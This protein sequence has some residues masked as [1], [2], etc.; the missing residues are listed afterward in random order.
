MSN[1]I[2]LTALG[3]A[4]FA[5]R[6]SIPTDFTGASVAGAGDVNGD[7]FDDLLIGSPYAY[8]GA[9]RP[10]GAHLIFGKA[11]GFATVNL[12]SLAAADGFALVGDA[13]N[14][15]A[16]R[17]VASA[18]DVNGDG[19]DD[20]I[21]AA[22]YGDDGGSNAGEAYVVFGKASGLAAVD[23]GALAEGDGAVLR[24]VAGDVA[25]R[26]VAGAGDFNGDGIGD[27]IVGATGKDASG[28]DSGGAY[29]VFGKQTLGGAIDMGALGDA[30]GFWIQG[31]GAF[32]FMGRSVASAG[33]I[34][35]DGFDDLLV[36]APQGDSG[37]TDAG[38]AYVIFGRGPNPGTINLAALTPSL[39]FIVKGGAGY[40]GAGISVASAG[41]VN[42]DGFADMLVAASGADPAGTTYVVFGK[43][44]GFGTVDLGAL[45]PK[46][47]FAIRGEAA[48]LNTAISV[49]SA[50]DFN[51]DGFDDL[52]IGAPGD[53]YFQADSGK[54]YI[55]YGKAE[56]F[57]PID[58]GS[59]DA[60]EGMVITGG[61]YSRV[62]YSVSSAG[63]VNGD[64][65][66]DVIVGDPESH[67][68]Q[69]GSG[70]AYVIFGSAPTESVTRIGTRIAQSIRGGLGD[71]LLDGRDG[72][73]LLFGAGGDDLLI[74][75]GG[76]DAL[77]GDAGDDDLSGGS[78]HD[79]LNGGFDNDRLTGGSG[80][81][82]LDG[83]AGA[84][85][86]I[87]GSGNDRY[88]V[89]RLGDR[90]V[91]E[92]GSGAD[93]LFARANYT[94]RE[95]VDIETIGT[96][97]NTGTA[98][99]SLTG[100]EIAN[101]ITGNAGVNALAGGGGA[102]QLFGLAGNDR[103]S[104]GAGNDM[105]TGG[106]GLD[107]FV[108][109]TALSASANV[110]RL[111]DFTAVDDMIALDRSIFGGIPSGVL[112][113]AAFREGTAAQD[114]S[115]RIIYDAATGNIFYDADGLNGAAQTLF[116]R[117]EAGTPLTRVDFLGFDAAA[118]ASAQLPQSAFATAPEHGQ[119][120]G[121]AARSIH[122]DIASYSG[123]D[124]MDV[125]IA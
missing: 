31:S 48:M 8:S 110:D 96:I 52:I 69:T 18:G 94:L 73:D 2:D 98:A 74:G 19:L 77:S 43:A 117:V 89:D 21:V 66:D 34:N 28:T 42:G 15:R 13:N 58:L 60:H 1:L 61:L 121:I 7:G 124:W 27:L 38:Q 125:Q 116:A 100:N 119:G 4:G 86:L 51:G 102:D 103:L 46:A 55:V 81:D 50:G 82:Q 63:D 80:N 95:G 107:R 83:G 57:G 6:G 35:R 33:D 12:S 68:S 71:D 78:G 59:L 54:A 23:L 65:F 14:D 99:I 47:G 20:F 101:A 44:T 10:G 3:S 97:A 104:G 67:I 29:V 25:G 114:D 16:G 84:D 45:A 76:D 26:S 88:I 93:R 85:M 122:M 22:P 32:N 39:G 72:N 79:G 30:D 41:D 109:D 106:A 11:S 70:S 24:G 87:G 5:I 9:D 105:A 120:A 113:A 37:G 56:G 118:S 90:I 62:G 36:G 108:F 49:A 75:G 91:E 111:L 112:T 64:G 17:S 53:G 40:D 123:P 92:E 115:D